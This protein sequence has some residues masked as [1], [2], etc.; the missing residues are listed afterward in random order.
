MGMT[1]E[2]YT[3]KYQGNEKI[4]GLG[5][6]NV[7][8]HSPCPFCAEPEFVSYLIQ[9]V[10]EVLERGAVCAHC[11]RGARAVFKRT[12]GGVQFELVQTEGDAIPE[13]CPPMRH[14]RDLMVD[15]TFNGLAA[16]VP[17]RVSFDALLELFGMTGFPSVT[18]KRRGGP[19]FI[20]SPAQTRDLSEGDVIDAVHTG[21][22]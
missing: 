9:D 10:Q 1:R 18:V 13:W 11:K 22:A 7:R 12:A 19:G 16:R 21:N 5:L 20:F 14:A 2:Q 8:M 6:G 15:V 3:A 4:T 17:A